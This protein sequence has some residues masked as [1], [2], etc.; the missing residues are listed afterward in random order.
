MSGFFVAIL[1]VVLV[2]VVAL[3]SYAVRFLRVL[4]RRFGCLPVLVVG[5]GAML[6]SGGI[7][8]VVF[9]LV[10]F[11]Y[12]A[13]MKE[14]DGV[15]TAKEARE[16]RLAKERENL[17]G[18]R[19][20]G[21]FGG[22][23]GSGEE[24]RGSAG[25][26]R[27]GGFGSARDDSGDSNFGSRSRG[28]GF[29]SGG[30]RGSGEEFR[31]SAGYGRSGGVRGSVRGGVGGADEFGGLNSR[32]GKSGE[33]GVSE[34]AVNLGGER[35][36]LRLRESLVEELGI[37]FVEFRSV[38]G[39]IESSF[40]RLEGDVARANVVAESGEIFAEFTRSVEFWEQFDDFERKNEREVSAEVRAQVAEKK[41]EAVEQMKAICL[42]VKFEDL[43]NSKVKF[44]YGRR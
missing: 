30:S 11:V 44:T 10:A 20:S 38:F 7:A 5:V 34:F 40:G 12:F 23:R 41:S 13:V 3:F 31:G 22:V 16:E 37:A 19:G 24:F 32:G 14:D 6:V 9:V 42:S 28:G 26:G 15:K 39:Y 1:V 36:C 25:Y 17:R 8:V 2:L 27:S 35:F 33:T 4:V 18:S 43:R 21:D 29:G